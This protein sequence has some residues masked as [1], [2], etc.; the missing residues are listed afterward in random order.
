M[1]EKVREQLLAPFPKN[2]VQDPPKGKFGKFVNHAVYVE[3]LRDCKVK[4]S[5][6]F[7]PT[8][9][10][11]LVVGGI[12]TIQV[13]GLGTFQGAGD[14]ENSALQRA[15][16]GECMK[17]AESDAFKRAC[18]RFGLGVEL[19]SGTD[20]FFVDDSPKQP[21]PK[22]KQELNEWQKRLKEATEHHEKDDT[23][24]ETYKLAAWKSVENKD[25][26]TWTD[27]DFDTY[28]D[29]FFELQNEPQELKDSRLAV[30]EIFGDI[31]DITK[32][33]PACNSPD[34]IEDNRAK[35]EQ[36]EKF[37]NI[38]DFACS[39]FGQNNGCGWGGYKN[40]STSEKLV[41]KEWL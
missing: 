26:D 19:W 8:I 33:C 4:Y 28:M 21:A 12:G 35:K 25:F 22:K 2:V 37:K 29:A 13:E 31:K 30:E 39:N 40:S 38:P 5:W 41:P 14:V 17:L 9:I 10:D 18:M 24:R 36:D 15:T 20:D 11:G 7:E 16:K 34:W 1:E 32:N 6:R 23:L 27:E 3:R